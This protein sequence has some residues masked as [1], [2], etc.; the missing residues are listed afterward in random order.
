MSI[1]RES[2]YTLVPAWKRD[3][4]KIEAEVTSFW[5]RLGILP[6]GADPRMR[7]K[8]VCAV[9][10]EGDRVIAVAT[11]VIGVRPALRYKFA[12]YRCAVDPDRRGGEVAVH[13]TRFSKKILEEWA[14][15]H[16]QEGVMGMVAELQGY[17]AART[18]EPVWPATGLTLVGRTPEGDQVRLV[19]FRHARLE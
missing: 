18:R 5:E 8:Q 2:T 4:P 19:W 3:D 16:P 1:D 17:S 11:A 10:Y 14:A 13:L 7:V 15:E 12:N 6:P 9:A